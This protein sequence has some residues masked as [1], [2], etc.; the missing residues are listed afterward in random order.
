MFAASSNLFASA[1]SVV[2]FNGL[3]YEEWSEQ[4]RFTLG[5][6]T[7]DHAILT[8]EEPS[9]ITEES[10]ETEKSRYESWERS[11]RLSLNLMRMT[12]AESVK[13]SMPKTEKAREFIKKI[14]ECSQSDLADKSIVGGLMSELT[15]KK[16]D[17]SQPIH[18]HVT[19]M[20][21]LASKLTT[22]GMEVHEPFLVQFIMNSLPLEFSQFQV[23]YNTIK[24]KW[25][26]QELK[27]M[28]VQEEGR[29][30]K[31]KDQVAHLVGLGSASSRKGKSSIKD[32]KM[33]KTFVKGPE[34]QIHKERK[35]FFCKKMGHFK[36]DCPKRKAWFDKKGTQH[37][38]VCSE[39]NLIEVPNNTWWLDSGATTHVSHIEQGFSSIQPIR[40]A[41]Q[42]LF[43]GNRMK[44]RIEGIGTYR[45][46]L[47]T[48]CHVDLEGCLYVPECSRNLVS[49][50][51][52]DN[53]GFVFKIGH[54][55]FSLYRN[56]YLYGSGTL[57]DSLYRFNLDAK[58]SESL[59]NIESQGIKRSASNESSAFLWHQ[60]L[61]HISKE[62]IMRL[63]KNDILPQLDFSDLNV[64]I[65]CI[66][67]KQTKHIVKKPATRS[68]QLLEL[69]HTDICGPFD[70][71]SW[72]G[73][74]YF[75]TFIDDYSR[76]G[77]TYLLHEK[78]KSVNILEVFIDEVERQLDRKVKVVRSDR[79]G[80]F[81]GKFTESG[82]CPGP[83]AKLLESRGICAQYTM[84][85]TPQQNGVA[86]RRNRTLMDMVRSMLSNSSLPLS[87]WIYA[88]KTATYVLNRVPSK[89]VPKTPFELW[90]GRKPSLRHLRVWGC[91]AEVKSY[92][93]HEKKLD[94]RTVSGFFIGYPEK[95]KGYTFYCPNHSTR[96]VET[97]NARFIENG[98]TSGSG[99]SRKVDIQEIQVE[100]SSPDVPSKVVVP[101]V[102]VQSNDTIEQHDD[103]PIPLDEGT[104]NEPVT[105]QEENN[106][107]P[108]EPLRR[109]GRER[110]S[111]ISNDYVVYAIE[112]ECDISLDEDP[113]TFRKAM[114]SD[115]S[116]KWSI[117]AKEEIKSMGDNDVWD[118][119]ELPNGFKTVGSKWVFKTKRD[120]KGNIE[121]YK[122][123]LVAKGFTQ[124]D[125]IDYKETFSP[126]S[127]KDSLRIVLGLVAHYDLE[128]H[129]MDVKTAF[130]NGELEEEVYM[131]QPEGFVATGNEHLVCKLK[132]SIYGL[133]QASRQWYLKFN[134]TITSYGFVEVIV[135]R[136]IYIKVSGSK[137]VILVLYVDDILL[138]A[139][140]MGMLHDIKKYLSKNFEMKDMGEASYVIG[141]EIIR[142]RSQGLLSLSQKGYINKILE[143]YRMDECSAGKAPIQKGD[144]FSKM[145]CP[146]NELERKEMERIP[147]ASVVGSLNYVQ[148]CTRPDISFAVGML[149]R[150]QSNPGMDHWKAAKKVLRY[151]Q[152]T[153]ELMLTYRRSDNLEVI[154]YSDSDYAGCVDS[155]KS[156][157]GY[158]FL[159]AGGAI[160]WKSGKQSVIA[161]STM[162]AEFVACFEATIHALWLR[163]FI[164]GLRIVDSI[165]K[166]L[167][168]YCDNSA[169]VFFSKNDKYSKGAKHMEL[170]YLSVKEEVQKR[171][172]SFEHIR[173]D[174]M[175]ADPL[176]K[177]L[178]PKAF[179][180][181]VERMGI[182]DKALLF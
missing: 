141:I 103:V 122:A 104:I 91:P 134:D 73:E 84:P 107:V 136:C 79:G 155:R 111:A 156:T 128:L 120:S 15:T 140:D 93:P 87:L 83:F 55:V 5:V 177:G 161:T 174:M 70:A 65:D 22:L 69:I 113:I 58:F 32:K 72:S 129:Q 142:D 40:G 114:E 4:I 175:V 95:S 59:F 92:N 64:C 14:K 24:D 26:Y 146:R 51:R 152:G 118:L 34:S 126:V 63:V 165:E 121:R 180:G 158:L 178:P 135:D 38:Y 47:D 81:Y 149:G 133:K 19:H 125:G 50:S 17:W 147:Y 131:D 16:F 124:K 9:A 144:K 56:D 150:Y 182:I 8:D 75:I 77:F 138:A 29:L 164:S 167:R 45:L 43:M 60:R 61:G 172:V 90:T 37:I 110:R 67:G 35:C 57:F 162:E 62:R 52:L 49:V 2:K 137:F 108:Q 68:T 31:M 53:L 123:R 80:E 27:A 21:N 23:N 13:P 36:K 86:E 171:R 6:M 3:N 116:E 117:A 166:P 96:I 163:N 168:I 170:K 41:D 132:K 119:V 88:L 71:P 89:A 7:L 151:L 130:L 66:K 76:Y 143:R 78:S 18:D 105:I 179:I 139:N 1:N 112:S 33:D 99:E 176:T 48:G 54:G 159:L 169:A 148:T 106:S 11:N 28:L 44:A 145:Q 82:Q 100:V 115:N 74:K 160:S 25:N 127:K 46:I 157:F 109:S 102:S 97:G 85:G 30:K 98:Q 173:T 39:L 181:H 154:G 42:Y 20:S 101:I 153:K 94:S 10:S 12:M